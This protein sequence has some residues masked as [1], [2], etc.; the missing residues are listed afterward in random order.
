MTTADEA[1]T[2]FLGHYGVKGMRWGVRRTDAQLSKAAGKKKSESKDSGGGEKKVVGKTKTAGKSASDM[3]DKQL[4]KVVDRLNTEQQ[5]ARLTAPPPSRAQK[6]TKF[7]ADIAVNVARTQ[8]TQAANAQASKHVASLMASKA[9]AKKVDVD[10]SK[11]AP[12]KDRVAA[13][14]PPLAGERRG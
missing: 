1:A 5:Y 3:S 7:F 14:P 2:D 12:L 8:I 9:P 11:I 6:T 4:K 10:F 13:W